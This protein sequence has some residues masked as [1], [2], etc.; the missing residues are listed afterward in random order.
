M[1]EP[2]SEEEIRFMADSDIID[3]YVEECMRTAQSEMQR[4]RADADGFPS[5]AQLDWVDAREDY[6]VALRDAADEELVDLAHGLAVFAGRAGEEAL[7]SQLQRQAAW[8][9][10]RRAEAD[11]LADDALRLRDGWLRYVATSEDEDA[12]DEDELVPAAAQAF[13]KFL[14]REMDGGGVPEADAARAD[15]IHAAATAG[16]GVAARFAAEFV[17]LADRFRRA[18]ET[19]AG[20]QEEVIAE[21]LRRRAAKV[22]E[23]CADPEALVPRM[24]ATGWWMF[25]RYM[26]QNPAAVAAAAQKPTPTPDA[27]VS[28]LIQ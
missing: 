7:V 12:E 18:A 24:Q 2:L 9:T 15:A 4:M 23:L 10:A 25:W 22:E 26:N 5:V 8:C 19:Y 16:R 3:P 21:G 27:S 20:R 1:G 6:A 11:A 14:A 17:E 28:S 13:L